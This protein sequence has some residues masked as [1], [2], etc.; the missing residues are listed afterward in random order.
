MSAEEWRAWA[1]DAAPELLAKFEE[2]DERGLIGTCD[3]CFRA[4]VTLIPVA[5]ASHICRGCARSVH[6]TQEEED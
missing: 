2:S 6:E 1:E 3:L 5:A 4:T